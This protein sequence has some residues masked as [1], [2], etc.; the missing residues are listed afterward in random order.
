MGALR[1]PLRLAARLACAALVTLSAAGCASGGGSSEPFVWADQYPADRPDQYTIGIGDQI[2]VAVFNNDR[3]STTTTVRSDGKISVPLL[4]D[5]DA[6]GKAPAVLAAD[7]EKKLKDAQLVLEPHVTVTV[8]QVARIS[9]AILG[10]VGRAGNYQLDPNAG[11]AEA[12]ATAGGLTD[13]AHKDRIFVV[14]RTPTPVRIRFTFQS[15]TSSTGK[16]AL[17]RL[18]AG[19]VVVAE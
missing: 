18:R 9:V 4:S 17:F 11:L 14:R 16:A 6:A 8:G 7:I 3:M 1:T 15:I 5:V 10:A 2:A 12:I 13:F 19:D